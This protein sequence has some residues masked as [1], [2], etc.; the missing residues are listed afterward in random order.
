MAKKTLLRIGTLLFIGMLVLSLLPALAE[1]ESLGTLRVCNCEEWVSL[2]KKP[3][4]SSE[5]LEKVPLGALV[6]DCVR[7]NDEF[8]FCNYEGKSGYILAE[9]LEKP[10]AEEMQSHEWENGSILIPEEQ[11]ALIVV[12]EL[13][14]QTITEEALPVSQMCTKEYLELMSSGGECLILE[15]REVGEERVTLCAVR[16]RSPQGETLT[17]AAYDPNLRYLWA[18]QMT[19]RNDGQFEQLAAFTGGSKEEP[20]MMLYNADSGLQ[21]VDLLTGDEKWTL[22]AKDV[23]LGSGICWAVEK[24]GTMYIAGADGPHPVAISE[25]GTVLWFSDPG[26]NDIYGPYSIQLL[27]EGVFTQYESGPDGGSRGHYAVLY[28]YFGEA[29]KADLIR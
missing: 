10:S 19:C 4:T 28:S 16:D 20:R 6:T 23:R 5:R 2:R 15:S 12:E 14:V 1:G 29:L 18:R 26:N 25:R 24:D 7:K 8:I 9:Y 17:V 11:E 3:K 13:P 22:S 27:P 21:A